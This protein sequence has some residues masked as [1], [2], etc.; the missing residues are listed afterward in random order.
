MINIKTEREKKKI[1][2]HQSQDVVRKTPKTPGQDQTGVKSRRLENYKER[3][4]TEAARWK[5]HQNASKPPVLC[6]SKHRSDLEL[7]AT[8]LYNSTRDEKKKR[9][10]TARD[11]SHQSG[12]DY[13]AQENPQTVFPFPTSCD[14]L[15]P[16]HPCFTRLALCHPLIITTTAQQ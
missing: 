12:D 3:P 8:Q 2:S 15:P 4:K 10:T 16:F 11:A 14:H 9:K 13:S 5:H 7:R 6:L 1:M